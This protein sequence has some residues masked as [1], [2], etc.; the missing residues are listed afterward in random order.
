MLSFR[1][2]ISREDGEDV[3]VRIDEFK[4]GEYH[5]FDLYKTTAKMHPLC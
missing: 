5:F 2:I 1:I 4:D 3:F